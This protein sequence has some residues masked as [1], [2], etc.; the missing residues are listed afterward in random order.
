MGSRLPAWAVILLLYRWR[1]RILGVL[2][3]LPAI[4]IPGIGYGRADGS[5]AIALL[6]TY[7]AIGWSP[8]SPT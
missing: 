6:V 1:W 4:L 2:L 5:W 8:C 7:G 3:T